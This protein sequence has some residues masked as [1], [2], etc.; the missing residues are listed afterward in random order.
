MRLVLP[1]F[2][3]FDGNEFDAQFIENLLPIFWNLTD[4]SMQEFGHCRMCETSTAS[5]FSLRQFLYRRERYVI[6]AITERHIDLY[7]V[8]GSARILRHSDDVRAI[9]PLG[10]G[11]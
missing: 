10:V 8:H 3:L 7:D 11:V 2:R 1:L 9:R 6:E 4:D 5:K